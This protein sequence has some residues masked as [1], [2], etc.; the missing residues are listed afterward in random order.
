MLF[1]K[2][3][4]IRPEISV[5]LFLNKGNYVNHHCTVLHVA[6]A[7]FGGF[8]FQI[9]A[10]NAFCSSLGS[11]CEVQ[12]F[13]FPS[14]YFEICYF[15][16]QI[17][18]PL[19]FIT[20]Q[21]DQLPLLCPLNAIPHPTQI[22]HELI[23]SVM[24]KHKLFNQ[25][26]QEYLLILWSY[27]SLFLHCHSSSGKCSYS[28]HNMSDES[29][30]FISWTTDDILLSNTFILFWVLFFIWSNPWNISPCVSV[31]RSQ[32]KTVNSNIKK[33]QIFSQGWREDDAFT[34]AEYSF[35]TS[36]LC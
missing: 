19:V 18:V 11:W 21:E 31:H 22:Y 13:I 20:W 7:I 5:N 36:H 17:N 26:L 33:V 12:K 10:L 30:W 32:V 24:N 4:N 23:F 29:N 28:F 35:A 6:Y 1:Q 14:I 16:C 27:P 2:P 3:G 15:F 25:L 8:F 34:E 9:I